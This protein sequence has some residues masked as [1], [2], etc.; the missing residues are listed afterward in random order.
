MKLDDN[1][2]ALCSHQIIIRFRHNFTH[3]IILRYKLSWNNY[4]FIDFELSF[5]VA[6]SRAAVLVIQIILTFFVRGLSRH[7]FDMWD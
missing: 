5:M 2:Q 1:E 7:G 3:R 4:Q 6:S